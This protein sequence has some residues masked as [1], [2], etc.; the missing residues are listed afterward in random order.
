MRTEDIGNNAG[1]VWHTLH[2]NNQGMT[3]QELMDVTH[4]DYFE[5]AT[6]IGWLARENKIITNESE[7]KYM[8][9]IFTEYYF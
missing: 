6:A 3:L 8:L 1:I 2:S 9:T 5:I 4:L 7:G